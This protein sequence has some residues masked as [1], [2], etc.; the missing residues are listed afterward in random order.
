MRT[1]IRFSVVM[2][3]VA[4]AVM[5]GR[6]DAPNVY[7]I[8]GARLVTAA[9]APIASGTL[10][11]RNGV[12]AAV[13]AGVPAP[14]GAVG[15][16]GA[17]LSVYPGLID[18]GNAAGLE[19]G[20]T[21]PQP[22]TV[23]TMDEAER[24]KRALLFRPELDAASRVKETPE[25]TR[26]ASA[27]ITSVLAT[28]PGVIFKG[29]SALVN[30]AASPDEP[31]IGSVGDY[32]QGMQIVRAPVAL[33]VELAANVRG[34]AYPVSLLGAISFVRQSF[35][36]AQYQHAAADRYEKART[37]AGRP[38]YDP[39][40]EA[41]LPALDGKLPVAFEAD[42][43][44]E[45]LRALAIAKEFKLDPVITGGREADRVAADLKGR[46]ARVIYSLNY[47]VRPRALAPDA[48]EPIAALR[49]R[50]Q[51]PKTPGALDKAG[52]S[53]AFSSAGLRDSRD[54]LKNAA[55]AVRDGLPPDAAV[56]ALT[57]SAAKI[58]GAADRLGSLENG[59]IANVI[60]TDGDLFDDKTKN[61]HV[62][63]D[64][65]MLAIEVAAP[66]DRR[67]RSGQ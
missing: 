44:R 28:P 20:S 22:A 6:A 4:T 48:D 2:A 34:D 8:T 5:A 10:V 32:R 29:R 59:K 42:S 15:I 37:A 61:N 55:R 33:H 51:A 62:F 49:A 35:I 39:A 38:N 19:T 26:L 46:N 66:P 14:A 50:A 23:R 12:I 47:P 16:D 21:Q 9:G 67:G 58:A 45:I 64:G 1:R 41:L 56:R 36:D 18:M 24:W 54:F 52:I 65:R 31:Q 60:V 3:A 43:A 40:L 63:V 57:I 13:G 25:L 17:G 7:A 11:I 53:F 27:G 30:V